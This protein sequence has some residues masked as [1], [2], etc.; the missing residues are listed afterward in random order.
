MQ[1]SRKG[2]KEVYIF[3]SGHMTKMATVPVYGKTFKNLSIYTH[4]ADYLETYYVASWTLV[5]LVFFSS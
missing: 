2:E 3:G 4:W 1:Q 5:L